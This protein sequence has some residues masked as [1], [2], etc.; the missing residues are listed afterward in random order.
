[1]IVTDLIPPP[2]PIN[3]ALPVVLITLTEPGGQSD[4]TQT[5]LSP[6]AEINSLFSLCFLKEILRHGTGM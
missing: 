1:M 2:L 3:S 6:D 5:G 4:R